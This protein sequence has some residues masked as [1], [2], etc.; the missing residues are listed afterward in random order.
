MTTAATMTEMISTG[1]Y[2][3]KAIDKYFNQQVKEA[4]KWGADHNQALVNAERLVNQYKHN[5][6][7]RVAK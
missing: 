6:L 5:F 1:T 7:I 2:N 4:K 3:Q